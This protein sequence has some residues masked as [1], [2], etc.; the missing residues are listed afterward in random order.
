MIIEF[1]EIQFYVCM[2][3]TTKLTN[4]DRIIITNESEL[5]AS[6]KHQQIK[7]SRNRRH[8][9]AVI[10]SICQFKMNDSAIYLVI[11]GCCNAEFLVKLKMSV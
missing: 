6:V 1:R 8:L 11:R 10:Q 9:Y 3:H 5:C 2:K 7:L 4:F